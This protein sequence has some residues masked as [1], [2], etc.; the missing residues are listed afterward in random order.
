MR[1][2]LGTEL[3]TEDRS[4]ARR[5]AIAIPSFYSTIV[6]ITIVAAALT[7][8]TATKSTV[9]PSSEQKDLLQD[10]SGAQLYRPV[11][12]GSLPNLIAACTAPQPCM[13]Q[14]QTRRC[15]Q[16]ERCPL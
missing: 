6:V 15:D 13:G 9:V 1:R 16:A 2:P 7:S 11:P 4:L 5:W 3:N 8:S 12:Y 14:G 10:R